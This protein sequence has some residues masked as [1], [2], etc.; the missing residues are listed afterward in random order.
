MACGSRSSIWKENVRRSDAWTTREDG[1][2]ESRMMRRIVARARHATLALALVGCGGDGGVTGIKPFT[3]P[4]SCPAGTGNLPPSEAQVTLDPA[5]RFQTIQGFGTTQRLFDDPHTTETF[6]PA[7][8]RASATPSSGDQTKILD[9]LYVDLGLTRVRFHPEGLE[10]VND[11]ADPQ[12]ADLSKFDFSWKASDGHIDAVKA[13]KSRGLATFYA[14]PLALPGWMNESNPDEYV[15]WAMVLLRHWREQGLEMPYFSILNEPGYYQG[16]KLWSGAWMREVTKRLGAR[17]KAEGFATKLV[18]PD[19]VS[20]ADAYPRL[21]AILAD[22]DARQYV[23]AVAYHLYGRGGEDKIAQIAKQYG[24]PVWMSEYSTP[25]DWRAWAG[26]MYELLAT[27][28]VSAIDYMWGFFGDWDRSQLIRIKVA[29]GNY[30]GFDISRQYYGM[31][32]YSRFVRPGA[33]RIAATSSDP[34]VKAVAF[35]SGTTPVIVVT[36]SGTHDRSVLFEL[37]SNAYCAARIESVRTSDTESWKAQPDQSVLQH[38]FV[39][40]AAAGSVT[41]FVLK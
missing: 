18:V 21:Q 32:Q 27:D 38:A 2:A 4:G 20:P 9:A 8:R 17:L 30:T 22:A 33:V 3:N 41:T 24:I 14:S 15:E 19:D 34:D 26:I 12:S 16:V 31:G 10:P 36:N 23:G 35:L 11:N 28:D 37:G 40:A 25:D 6:D 13:L 29:G 5:Q 1:M 39:A 7:T